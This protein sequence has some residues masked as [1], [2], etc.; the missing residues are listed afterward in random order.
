MILRAIRSVTFIL[1]L[2]VFSPAAM[3]HVYLPPIDEPSRGD[4]PR[5]AAKPL[6]DLDVGEPRTVRMIYFLPND[7]SYRSRTGS[8]R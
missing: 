1:L 3:A 2:P 6:A 4:H 5:P 7:R 8:I